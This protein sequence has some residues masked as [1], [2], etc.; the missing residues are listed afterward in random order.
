MA[1]PQEKATEG[2]KRRDKPPTRKFAKILEIIGG[3]FLCVLMVATPWLFGTT[4]DW[5]VR[6]MNWGSY[7]TG[8]IFLTAWICNRMTGNRAEESPRERMLKYL[9]MLLNVAVLLFCATAL[10]NARATFSVEDRSFN[11]RDSYHQSLPTTYDADL[12]RDT[13][14]SLLGC[15]VVFWSLRYWLRQGDRRRGDGE[16]NSI[17]RNKRFQIIAWVLSLNGF[18]VGLQ[19]ILQ[20]L[21]GSAKL[22][23]IR[24][25]WAGDALACFGP[26]SYRGNA[27]DYL[28]LLWPLALGF[29]WMMSR[30]RRRR[31]GSSRFITDGPELLLMPATIVMIGASIISLSRGGAVTTV[32]ILMVITALFLSQKLSRG[33]RFGAAIFVLGVISLGWFLGVEAL[34]KRFKTENLAD[35]GG[36]TEIYKNVQQMGEDFPV[37]GTGP[38]SFRSVY[39]LYRQETKEIWHGFLHDDWLETIVT[40][41]SVGFGLILANLLVLSFWILSAG[42]PP[43]FYGFPACATLGLAGVLVHAKYDLPFQTY[44]ILFTFVV[45]AALLSARSP[46]RG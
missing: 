10:W 39:H 38:G 19:G 6:L 16:E 2:R 33:A 41:G 30:E 21:S 1:A 18:A 27:S 35:L 43:L 45:I 36:R 8:A 15:F 13:L 31:M 23:W 14:L 9:F 20:R 12:T 28:N 46:A 26:F 25:S 24:D 32:G 44:S 3:V 34:S 4:E 42:R 11:Y 37:F 40:F 7:C 17:L 22:L 5:S 29:W